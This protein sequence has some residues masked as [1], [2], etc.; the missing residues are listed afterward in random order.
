M[1]AKELHFDVNAR[2]ALKR[3]VDQLAEAVKVTLGP[4]GRNVVIDKKFGSP[5]VTKDGVTVAKE[6]ELADPIENLS[7]E[8]MEKVG[9]DGVI[10]VE[11]AKGLETTLE[12][13]DGM[14]FDRGYLSPYFVTDPEKMEAVIEDGLILIHDK[15]ISSMKDLLPILEKV[16]QAGKPLLIIAE[17]V[18]GEALATL[19][20]NKLRG[21]LKVCAVKAPGF[22]DRR[23][24]MLRDIAI[25]TGAGPGGEGQVIS[26]EMGLKLEN[27]VLSDLGQ[28]KRIV[29]D[30][31]NTTLVG[32]KGKHD[33]I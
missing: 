3:G 9:K 15:K 17:D 33:K 20:V 30:K 12:T 13:V 16:A 7:A 6:V 22:G 1:A 5:T 8:A 21:T 23:K 26:E 24:E 31:D 18:E 28:A 2:A 19:V 11:E 4:K 32:G 29:V 27:A 10:T 25:L 14:Q